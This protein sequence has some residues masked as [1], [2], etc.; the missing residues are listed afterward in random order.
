MGSYGNRT[1]VA[2]SEDQQ[3]QY[4]C[5][6]IVFQ[7]VNETC[8][9]RSD[10][11]YA[12]GDTCSDASLTE[13]EKFL[14]KLAQVCDSAKGG[15]TITALVALKGCQG[16]DYLFAS[17]KRKSAELERTKVFLS[18]LIGYVGDNPEKLALKT[19]Q[20]KVLGRILEFNFS[21][22]NFYLERLLSSLAVCIS[23]CQDSKKGDGKFDRKCA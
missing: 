6:C 18:E 4:Q 23:Y 10:I 17:N 20:R 13:Y 11:K 5:L 3:R 19:L 1:S 15:D 16:P 14:C 2:S 9:T 12:S 8:K 22:L 7:A 21:R